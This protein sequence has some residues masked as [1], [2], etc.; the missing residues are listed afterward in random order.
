MVKQAITDFVARGCREGFTRTNE[1]VG[2][3]Q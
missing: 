3:I 1:A 2:E